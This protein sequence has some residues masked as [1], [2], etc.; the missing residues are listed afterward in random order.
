VFGPL[1]ARKNTDAHIVLRA[2]KV[3]AFLIAVVN[4]YSYFFIDLC[5][6]FASFSLAFLIGA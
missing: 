4:H 6:D 1:A 5:E 2:K 3:N